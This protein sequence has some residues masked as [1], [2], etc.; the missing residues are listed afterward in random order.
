[1]KGHQSS[2]AWAP[3]LWCL[4][5]VGVFL[6]IKVRALIKPENIESTEIHWKPVRN[7]QK[8]GLFEMAPEKDPKKRLG[9]QS[10]GAPSKI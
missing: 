7:V 10:S 8:N 3:K 4:N 6:F 2:G 1:M 9:H 5:F